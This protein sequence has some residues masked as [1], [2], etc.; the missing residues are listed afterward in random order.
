MDVTLSGAAS[1]P[2]GP[3]SNKGSGGC[4]SGFGLVGLIALTGLLAK[5]RR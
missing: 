2:D 1:D 5:R 3:T 4:D